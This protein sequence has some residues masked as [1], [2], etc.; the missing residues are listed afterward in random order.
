M[1]HIWSRLA[2][3]FLMLCILA[4]CTSAREPVTDE[5]EKPDADT[6]ERIYAEMQIE[7]VSFETA[8]RQS[9]VGVRAT[10]RES[11][12][13]KRDIQYVF[14]VEQ[15][16]FGPCSDG[17]LHLFSPYADCSVTGGEKDGYTFKTG[18]DMYQPGKTY[19]LLLDRA[20]M[21]FYDYPRFTTFAD[22]TLAEDENTYSMYGEALSFGDSAPVDAIMTLR[23]GI[24]EKTIIDQITG[25]DDAE[26]MVI[27]AEHVAI[28][29]L[30]G[31]DN[32][33]TYHNGI[34]YTAKIEK[35]LTDKTM[36]TRDDGTFMLVLDREATQVGEKYLVGFN[37]I[38]GSDSLIYM[39]ATLS[40]LF[41]ADDQ[42]AFDLVGQYL[43]SK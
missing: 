3:L 4:S 15:V 10:F 19:I 28:V 17:E 9:D 29:K 37:A 38:G 26:T 8:V 35:S 11:I 6:G 43:A 2:G 7:Y 41:K 16:L 33:E 30:V 12:Y 22:L 31:I 21:I 39:Q 32:S 1:K 25:N 13:G 23:E 27:N 36:S 20:D 40:G 42:E 18:T 14:D 34:V 5:T 24:P